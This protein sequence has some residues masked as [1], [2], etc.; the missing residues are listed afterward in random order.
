MGVLYAGGDI[1]KK[2]NEYHF[3]RSNMK[4]NYKSRGEPYEF[5]I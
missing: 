4:Y 2:V 5:Y 3:H 1:G